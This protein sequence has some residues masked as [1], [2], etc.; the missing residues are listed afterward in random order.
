MGV[1][2]S[3]TYHPNLIDFFKYLV[4]WLTTPEGNLVWDLVLQA[5]AIVIT[6]FVIQRWI[7]KREEK[8]WLPLKQVTYMLLSVITDRLIRDLAPKEPEEQRMYIY[9]FG[10]RQGYS[11]VYEEYMDEI[12][13]MDVRSFVD[14]TTEISEN[15][16]EL[17]S[18]T[19]QEFRDHFDR[20]SVAL[21]REPE[22]SRMLADLDFALSRAL[23]AHKEPKDGGSKLYLAQHS[24]WIVEHAYELNEGLK[25]QADRV[26]DATALLEQFRDSRER[27]QARKKE[28]EAQKSRDAKGAEEAN[29]HTN[30]DEAF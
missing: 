3:E 22:I 27:R 25:S 1:S 18:D 29:E 9:Y 11:S 19:Y 6:V 12:L 21:A 23:E 2:P 14:R 7:D 28:K 26:S 17:L 16:S 24:K 15:H 5:L 13:S 4:A 8:R 10:D 30:D 20:G